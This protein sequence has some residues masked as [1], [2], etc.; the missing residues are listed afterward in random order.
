MSVSIKEINESIWKECISL[1]GRNISIKDSVIIMT[2]NEEGPKP[3]LF[4]K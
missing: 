4:G 1:Q 3:N 2:R